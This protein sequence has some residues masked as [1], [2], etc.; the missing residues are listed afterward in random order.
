MPQATSKAQQR[1]FGIA[2]EVKKFILS[3]GRKGL[4]PQSISE[5][6]RGMIM[7]LAKMSKKKLSEYAHT[8]HKGLPERK[9]SQ[10]VDENETSATLDSTSGMGSTQFPTS[11]SVGSG[12][13]PASAYRLKRYKEWRKRKK[14][15]VRRQSTSG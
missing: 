11:T 1:Y 13:A 5:E 6:F 8:K 3:K 14:I 4:D 10:S 2:Y 12:D 9:H 7:D 15:R